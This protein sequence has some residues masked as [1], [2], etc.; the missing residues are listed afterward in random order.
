MSSSLFFVRTL[1]FSWFEKR[2]ERE[3]EEEKERT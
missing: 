3:T 1:F 2:K